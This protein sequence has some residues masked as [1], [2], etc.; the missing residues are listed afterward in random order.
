[1]VQGDQGLIAFL[2][3]MD[4]DPSRVDVVPEG[5]P[6]QDVHL[7]M[8]GPAAMKCRQVFQD[9]W[10][11]HPATLALDQ[12]LGLDQKIAPQA[13]QRVV[14]AFPEPQP[15]SGD[16]KSVT[17]PSGSKLAA[18]PRLVSIGRTFGNL[19]KAGRDYDYSF[20]PQGDYSAWQ[21][22]ERG[23]TLAQR[24]IYLEDQYLVSR[25]AR[26]AMLS[27]ISQPGF[28]SLLILMNG[29]PAA[30]EDIP[31]AIVAR[32]EFRRDL[33]RIDPQK[34]KWGMYILK[35]SGD[36]QRRQWCG[37]YVHSKTWIFD[38]E[39]AI[40]GSANC[41]NRGYTYDTEV[42]AGIADDIVQ[43]ASGE[44]FAKALRIAL[45][46]KILGIPHNQLRNWSEATKLWH[47]PSRSSMA[48]D[49]SGPED[50]PSLSPPAPFPGPTDAGLY[51]AQW[52][53]IDPDAR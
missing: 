28:Q 52:K 49:A 24:W 25:I 3:G 21:L 17:L 23:I 34:S 37:T 31:W 32:N 11:D 14:F 42:V 35:D 36:D 40:V 39:Y 46:H 51:E 6:Y 20:A 26:Q 8:V 10:L 43:T 44:G 5:R 18:R 15:S 7:R 9:R 22:I 38:D 47:R 13:P 33:S 4:I 2:G 50:E 53:L 27:K 30:E 29:S 12:K 1:V 48:L 16:L 41:D 19:R 45:W